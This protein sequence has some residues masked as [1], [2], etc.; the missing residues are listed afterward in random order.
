MSGSSVSGTHCFRVGVVAVGEVEDAL[1]SDVRVRPCPSVI[2]PSSNT[3]SRH[4]RSRAQQ[5]SSVPSKLLVDDMPNSPRDNRTAVSQVQ[6]GAN[7]IG[8]D[9]RRAAL[10]L[11]KDVEDFG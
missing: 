5:Q 9:A 3:C 4:A 7:A 6:P 8:R 10:D 11:E 2:R 1:R